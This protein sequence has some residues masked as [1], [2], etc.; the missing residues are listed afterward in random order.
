MIPTARASILDVARKVDFVANGLSPSEATGY[1]HAAQ[2]LRTLV[3][4]DL[5]EDA[6]V[7]YR[8]L[9]VSGGVIDRDDERVRTRPLRELVKSG[10]AIVARGG[11]EGRVR[12]V[13]E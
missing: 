2:L 12:L 5:S 7:L 3:G 4:S 8:E 13:G 11:S 10:L 1:H 9:C 6:T